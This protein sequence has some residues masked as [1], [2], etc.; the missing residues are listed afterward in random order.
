MR[1]GGTWGSILSSYERGKPSSFPFSIRVPHETTGVE[2]WRSREQDRG[3]TGAE[4]QLGLQDRVPVLA[5][6]CMGILRTKV[7]LLKLTFR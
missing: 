2:G 5:Q 1:V 7:S 6:H 3:V 4:T